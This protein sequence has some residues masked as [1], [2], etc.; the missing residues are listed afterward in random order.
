MAKKARTPPPPRQQG[1]KKRDTTLPSRRSP[2]SAVI[3][4][5]LVGVAIVVAVILFMSLRNKSSSNESVICFP[6]EDMLAGTIA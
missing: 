5:V 2:R 4:G 1:P 3:S 6:D